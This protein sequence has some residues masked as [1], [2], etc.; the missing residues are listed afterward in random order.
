STC[1][2]TRPRRRCAARSA[3]SPARPPPGCCTRGS[4]RTPNAGPRRPPWCGGTS[5][6]AVTAAGTPAAADGWVPFPAAHARRY[7]AEGYW[8]GGPLGARLREWALCHGSATA[9]V[10]GPP[11]AP[12]RLTY[13]ELDQAV[14]DLAAGLARLGLR[15]GDRV[16]LHLPNRT[17]FVVLLFAL[18][19]LGVLPVL[20]LPAHR[21][22]EIEHLARL[23]GAV[24][25]AIPDTFEGFD[26]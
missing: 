25:Y 10:G 6:Q 3:T 17:E 11:G 15:P 22:V 8:E 5:T 4:S 23:A 9:L 18:L 21:R 12:V 26:H 16:L 2:S 14:D 19:R 13:A 20:T 24:A 1:R 7:L